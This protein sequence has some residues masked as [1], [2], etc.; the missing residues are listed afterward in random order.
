MLLTWN[1]SVLTVLI[2]LIDSFELEQV[3]NLACWE[4]VGKM[5]VRMANIADLN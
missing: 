5:F 2:L 1:P 4:Y 3:C